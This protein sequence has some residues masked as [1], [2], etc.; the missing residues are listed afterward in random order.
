MV[1]FPRS[2]WT[3]TREGGSWL[4][5]LAQTGGDYVLCIITGN[6]A[7]RSWGDDY[8]GF[9]LLRDISRIVYEHFEG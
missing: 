2:R 1:R 6:Q 3:S 9:V 8:E 4:G 5:R 7:D